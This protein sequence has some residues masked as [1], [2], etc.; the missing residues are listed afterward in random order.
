M[1]YIAKFL[2]AVGLAIILLGFLATFPRLMDRTLLTL[3]G[4]VFLSGWIFQTYGLKK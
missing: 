1:Y 2:Q 3:G 4:C